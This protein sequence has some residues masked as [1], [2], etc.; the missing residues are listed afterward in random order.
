MLRTLAAL[1]I[2]SA[3]LLPS[4]V[5]PQTILNT[6]G[7]GRYGTAVDIGRQE[8]KNV[9]WAVALRLHDTFELGSIGVPLSAVTP[10]GVIFE[11][12]ADAGG[13]PGA[14]IERFSIVDVRA[15]EPA[16]YTLASAKH[17]R[18]ERETQYWLIASPPGAARVRWWNTV[19]SWSSNAR[20]EARR[21]N[22]RAW[23]VVAN[24]YI[25]GIMVIGRSFHPSV[26]LNR[27]TAR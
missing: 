12:A 10:G 19:D 4:Q 7:A 3:V 21:E 15:A 6:I 23:E 24:P 1:G 22:G 5:A 25:P 18:L 27:E 9:E 13:A 17:P 20:L 8:D 16:M 14:A 11:L 2:L 26:A